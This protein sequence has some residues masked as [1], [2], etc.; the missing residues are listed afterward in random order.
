MRVAVAF[1]AILIAATMASAEP[2]PAGVIQVI[3]GDT[4]SA[5]GQT[6]RLVGFDTP[7]G[8]MNAQCEAERTL[9]AN[10]QA[11]PAR[12]RRR[13]RPCDGP[14]L[15][16]GGNGGNVSLQ[17]SASLWCAEGA[18]KDVAAVLVAE[19]LPSPIIAA[20]IAARAASL[21]VSPLSELL[22]PFPKQVCNIGGNDSAVW[23]N[24]HH[25]DAGRHVRLIVPPQGEFGI[26]GGLLYAIQRP[27]GNDD[28]FFTAP[29]HET[30]S[31]PN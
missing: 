3:D 31:R 17:L 28:V 1:L 9:A 7:E 26:D 24:G 21:G 2:I 22:S 6:V 15:L 27:R 13:S 5:R 11:A 29:Q 16:P 4:I 14:M 25:T 18:G 10:A 12:G 19:G 8:G 30:P 20:V 23:I